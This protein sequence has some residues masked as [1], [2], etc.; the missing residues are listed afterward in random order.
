MLSPWIN[1]SVRPEPIL[2]GEFLGTWTLFLK[3]SL[4]SSQGLPLAPAAITSRSGNPWVA[5]LYTW[6]LAQV[7]AP[8]AVSFCANLCLTVVLNCGGGAVCV[9]V[10]GVCRTAQCYRKPGDCVLPASLRCRGSGLSGS[11]VGVGTKFQV[12]EIQFNQKC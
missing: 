6:G 10:C 8:S 3:R 12:V 7:G 9:S 2:S 1:F 4:C 11:R 5:V